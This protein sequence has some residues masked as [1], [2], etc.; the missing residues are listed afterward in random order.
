MQTLTA[1]KHSCKI[2]S[3]VAALLLLFI[4]ISPLNAQIFAPEGLNMP[5]AW[6]GYT[7]P[8][9]A[10]SV[11]GGVQSAPG[12]GI[13]LITSGTPRY[14][15]TIHCAAAGDVVAG[16]Y[17]WLFTSGGGNPW[18]NKWVDVNV[19]MNTLQTYTFQGA[20]DNS[21][22]LAD[23]RWYTVNFENTGYSNTRGIF[24]ETSAAPVSVTSV[25]QL[26]VAGSVG[27]SDAVT[28]TANLSA[29]PASEEIVYLRYSTN[30]FASSTIVAMTVGGSSASAVIP[31]QAAA[32]GVSY[33][34]FTSTVVAPAIADADMVTIK[35]NNN[36][37]S[38]YNYTVNAASNWNITFRVNMANET[39]G[40]N[41]YLAGNFNGFST[42]ADPMTETAPGSGIY[43]ITKSLAQGYA[44]EY[45]FV[46]GAA[47]EGNLGAPCGNGSNRTYTVG[48]SDAT[49]STVCFGSCSNCVAPVN[50]TFRV[51]MSNETVGGSVNVSGSFN[52]WALAA[53]SP[54]G[55]GVYSYTT[56]I[57]PG[58]NI[59]YKFVNGAAYE[60]NLG[61][62]CGNG[63]NRTY[64]VPG[65]AATLPI[66]CF[67]SC[68][69]CVMPGNTWTSVTNGNWNTGSTWDQGTV[70]DPNADIVIAVGTSVVL[71]TDATINDITIQTGAV[72]NGSDGA[73]RTLTLISGGTFTRTGTFNPTATGVVTMSG[74][75]TITG[76]PAF[77]TLNVN[78]G[79]TITTSSLISGELSLNTGGYFDGISSPTYASNSVLKY[80]TGGTYGRGIEWNAT[81]GPGY[82]YHV[83]ITNNT[84]VQPGA[85]SGQNIA[86]AIAGNLTIDAGSAMYMDWGGLEMTQPI[87]IGGSLILNGNLS[88]SSQVGGD[89]NVKGNLT[90]NAGSN[91][92]ANGR[93]VGFNGT[94]AQQINGSA[95]GIT[96]AFV[97]SNNNAGV[98]LQMPATVQNDFYVGAGSFSANADLTLNNGGTLNSLLTI[99]SGKTLYVTGGTLAAN[100]SLTLNSGASL[101]HG[102]GT[103][104]GGGAVT[105]N[106]RVKR[107]GQTTPAFNFWSSPVIGATANILG[108][109][110]YLYD[111][112]SGTQSTADDT[113]DPGWIP[114]SAAMTAG[115]GY[116]SS[117]GGNVQFVGDANNGNISFGVQSPSLPA[118]RF[119]LVGNPYP[120]AISANAFLSANGPSGTNV[121]SGAIYFWDDDQSF[122][123]GYAVSDYA[124]WNGAGSVGGG[125]NTPNGNIGSGQGFFVE[126]NSSAN[127]SFSNS[128]RSNNNVQFF[129]NESISRVRL[130]ILNE[131]GDYNETLIAFV[132]DATEGID[133]NYDAAKLMG[134]PNIA[135][136]SKING[137]AYAI[138]GLPQSFEGRVV[139]LG[140]KGLNLNHTISL[141][142]IEE[143][144]ATTMIYL[145]DRETGAFINL[146]TQGSYNFSPAAMDLDARFSLHFSAPLEAVAISASC[147]GAPGA[148]KIEN[149]S[150][151]SFSYEVYNAQNQL[152]NEGQTSTE[153][154]IANLSAGHY[155]IRLEMNGGYTA[156]LQAEVGGQDAINMM[157]NTIEAEINAGEGI[158]LT[159]EANAQITWFV[160]GNLVAEGNNFSF[161]TDEAGVHS[162]TARAENGTCTLEQQII[163]TVRGDVATGIND[164]SDAS[165][166][167][168][169]N[170]A[171]GELFIRIP[172]QFSSKTAFIQVYNTLGKLVFTQ[173]S[174]TQAGTVIPVSLQGADSGLYL[175]TLTGSSERYVS[176]VIVK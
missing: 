67:G 55:G 12:N 14:Q 114:T 61:A 136:Y 123:S 167:V 50:V 94:S 162:V 8:P 148:V 105:G 159:A 64:T 95:L 168:F 153:V 2:L 93:S 84:T 138:Q 96:F 32:T 118:S 107:S 156:A 49:L 24:M 47:F 97:A 60:G 13:Q 92:S 78:G 165:F 133:G 5:G 101:M 120:S 69:D 37:G 176:R 79:V 19:V 91:F 87:T 81:S 152:V 34:V 169:P 170:P 57:V 16:S 124:V 174:A 20:V 88:L 116:A 63:S 143:I 36:G 164:A 102:A 146:R 104:G 90:V 75:N 71:N 3:N 108:S 10:G 74:N 45:K 128:M 35:L 166:S 112:A 30:G 39:V 134:N 22:T 27:S 126:A 125:G 62:P 86:R 23:N 149:A 121:I 73:V 76:G 115:R 172:E 129:Q 56:A 72:L 51:N 127:I 21:I 26:P 131:N 68:S 163:I 110:R 141:A 17:G 6:N 140:V 119:N 154:I 25:S 54:V 80:N 83:V 157:V 122:G 113:N 66:V 40:G 135:F 1:T 77:Q 145:E 137:E 150:A 11:F 43:E 38:N 109:Q 29:A 65:S 33:Y 41:V 99:L 28:V 130:S 48:T 117:A 82:P 46:N 171:A 139:E 59:E 100:G 158:E 142:G 106:I 15:T 103:P 160:N 175:I 52:G 70:P 89:L 42:V 151:E 4:F 111:P 144:P 85:N 155:V 58:S 44:A 7:N 98:T 147:D 53:M 9:A 18:A 173:T 161:E 31:A 132:S